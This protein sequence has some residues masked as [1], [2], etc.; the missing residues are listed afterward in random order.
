MVSTIPHQSP[1]NQLSRRSSSLALA[2]SASFTAQERR[3]LETWEVHDWHLGATM[4]VP[5]NHPYLI[6]FNRI[7]HYKPSKN[8]GTPIY[9][10]PHIYIYIYHT[11]TYI[12]PGVNSVENHEKTMVSR[13]EN[14]LHS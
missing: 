14:D 2:T 6:L 10:N 12:H 4:G 5:R 7:V 1:Y 11:H 3:N 9:G 13:S 8:L